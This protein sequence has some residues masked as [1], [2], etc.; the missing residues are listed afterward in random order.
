MQYIK[1]KDFHYHVTAV[2]RA[3]ERWDA[4]YEIH[5]N[6]TAGLKKLRAYQV[7]SAYGFADRRAALADAERNA[8]ADIEQ[9]IVLYH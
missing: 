1:Y 5:Q 2:Q 6:T 4:V 8:R 3:N 7:Q 9:G